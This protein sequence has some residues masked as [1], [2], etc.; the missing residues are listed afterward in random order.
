MVGGA[1]TFRGVPYGAPAFGANRC[2]RG[3]QPVAEWASER[4][5]TRYGDAV[6]QAEVAM[7]KALGGAPP[8]GDV[9]QMGDDCLNL[10][11]VTPATSGAHPV[12]VWVHGG[13][14]T[15]GSNKGDSVG[16]SPTFDDGWASLGVCAVAVNYRLALHGFLHVP[17]AG[18]TNLA[19]RDLI[20]ALEWVRAEIGAFG[21]DPG[22]VTLFGQSP[23]AINICR[24]VAIP[25]RSSSRAY[26]HRATSR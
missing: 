11:I 20:G 2:W 18:V 13:S 10:N 3:P 26:L 16:A 1:V 9:G 17:E 24:R 12:M 14:N 22:N 23:G 8:G 21:G 15:T 5:C 7:S 4:D 19:L 25:A 6:T